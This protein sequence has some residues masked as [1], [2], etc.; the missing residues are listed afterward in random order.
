MLKGRWHILYKKTECALDNIQV[1]IMV[2]ITLRNICIDRTDPCKPRW[3]LEVEELN[4]IRGSGHVGDSNATRQVMANW[5]WGIR[6]DR[7]AN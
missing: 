2:C 7:D 6:E 5:L 1:I 3:R 4:L